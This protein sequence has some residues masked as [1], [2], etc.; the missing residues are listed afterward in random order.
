MKTRRVET[1]DRLV[2]DA[3]GSTDDLRSKDERPATQHTGFS[4][5]DGVVSRSQN[6]NRPSRETNT[7]VVPL[8]GLGR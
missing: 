3:D 2:D 7:R 4:R 1:V 8:H 6:L 5:R